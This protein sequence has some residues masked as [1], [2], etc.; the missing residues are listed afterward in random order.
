MAHYATLNTHPDVQFVAVCDSTQ[1]I[2]KS[3]K[4]FTPLSVFTDYQKMFDETDLD[5]VIVATP[6]AS[7]APLA[8][9]A[10]ERGIHVFME[11]PFV[12]D[13]DEGRA[14]VERMKA[15]SLINQIGYFLRFNSVFNEVKSHLNRGMI[16]RVI[17]YKNEMYGCTVLKA[18]KSSWRAKKNMGGGCMMDFASHCLDLADYL[19]G[20]VQSISGG[21]LRSIYSTEVED[22]VYANLHHGNDT[23][24]SILTNWSDDA[25]RRPYNRIEILGTEGK[26]IADRQEY[27]LYLR[28]PDPG[29][30]FDKGWNVRYLPQIEK[31]ARIS[32][33]GPEFTHQ[34]DDFIRCIQQKDRS[35]CGFEDALRTDVVMEKILH[36]HQ[37]RND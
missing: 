12:L 7:H 36:D 8:R 25:Y 13:L 10:A 20:P 37:A 22:A 6:T 17:H 11:K 32:I 5:F 27:R 34:L 18:S 19:I 26:I 31:S 29:G 35:V 24:G 2:L 33:R 15:R 1:F 30:Q 4:R 28:E 14:L 16:G 3:L 21:L 9:A 23:T